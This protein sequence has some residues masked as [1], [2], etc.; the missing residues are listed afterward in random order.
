MRFGAVSALSNL[1]AKAA[2]AVPA[3][4]RLLSDEDTTVR[5][6]A[7]STLGS[8]GSP[9]LVASQDLVEVL[10]SDSDRDVRAC[11]A[12]T[13]GLLRNRETLPAL[14][15]VASG[16]SSLEVRMAALD[17]LRPVGGT[18]AISPLVSLTEDPVEE[19]QTSAHVQLMFLAADAKE[20]LWWVLPWLFA[21]EL[22]VLATFLLLWVLVASRVPRQGASS[23]ARFWIRSALAG[24]VPALV[25]G[26]FV[27]WLI[28]PEWCAGFLPEPFLTQVPISVAGAGS[29]ALVAGLAGV[30]ASRRPPAA[31]LD[32]ALLDPP[33]IPA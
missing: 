10:E 27:Y 15:G 5:Y 21:K 22:A 4:R 13:L 32:P 23:R 24:G 1:G 8:V 16:D 18:D 26:L 30:W 9:G 19:V 28:A 17:A 12:Y 29:A 3:L 11:A 14:V 25:T 2:P 6:F 31:P 20:P 7:V 33:P